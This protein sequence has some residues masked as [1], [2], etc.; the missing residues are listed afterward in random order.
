MIDV[1]KRQGQVFARTMAVWGTVIIGKM[2]APLLAGMII[3][4]V[5]WMSTPSVGSVKAADQFGI[6]QAAQAGAEGLKSTLQYK[7]NVAVLEAVQKG[8]H[9][10]MAVAYF[11]GFCLCIYGSKELA[12]DFVD[13]MSTDALKADI[14]VR[15]V[16]LLLFFMN[17][18]FLIVSGLLSGQLAWQYGQL[19]KLVSVAL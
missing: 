2:S 17:L 3:L 12:K 18:S 10:V 11:I 8:E 19:V 15:R 6:G 16:Y 1:L 7:F 4:F 13:A 5:S 9:V 14:F